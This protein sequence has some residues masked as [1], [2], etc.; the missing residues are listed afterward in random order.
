MRQRWRFFNT[1]ALPLATRFD[2]GAGGP[3]C[4]LQG[5]LDF[6]I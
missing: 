6:D 4:R 5:H 1:A 3:R 2:A